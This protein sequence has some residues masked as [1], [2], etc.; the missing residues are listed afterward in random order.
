MPSLDRPQQKPHLTPFSPV[1]GRSGSPDLT[2]RWTGPDSHYKMAYP[3]PHQAMLSI[4]TTCRTAFS[5]TSFS[6]W[7]WGPQNLSGLACIEYPHVCQ[8]MW[9]STREWEPQPPSNLSDDTPAIG[10]RDLLGCIPH[11]PLWDTKRG[12]GSCSDS[13]IQPLCRGPGTLASILAISHHI[14]CRDPI[15]DPST[16]RPGR[17]GLASRCSNHSLDISADAGTLRL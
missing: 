5:D 2:R 4:G 14:P 16:G 17:P 15:T 9:A 7:L 11:D 1:G 6:Q 3:R 12:G 13:Q 8:I 10:T